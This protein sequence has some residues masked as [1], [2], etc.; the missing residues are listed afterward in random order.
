MTIHYK[1]SIYRSLVFA[2]VCLGILVVTPK[3]VGQNSPTKDKLIVETLLRLKRY[4]VSANENWKSAIDRHLGTI[5]GT[6]RYLELVE[7]FGIRDSIPDLLELVIASPADTIGVNAAILLLQFE[8]S[9]LLRKVIH[10]K[11]NIQAFAVAQALSLGQHPA[12]YG[13]L[14]P[15]IID[16]QV[17]RQIRNVAIKGVGTT[18]QG[19]QYLIALLMSG[20][21]PEELMF[22]TGTAL[23][24][25]SNPDIVKS[26][27]QLVSLPKTAGAA[28]LPPVNELLGLQGDPVAGKLVFGKNGT[29]IKCHKIREVGKEIGPSLTEIGSKL[30]KEA[31]F[32]SI[33][34]PS[35][36]VS[37]NYETYAI[38]LNSGNVLSGIV[39]SRSDEEVVVRNAEGIDRVIAVSNIDEII[40]TGISLMPADLQKVMTVQELVDVVAYL[41]QLK[42]S[43][44]GNP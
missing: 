23:F 31:L 14:K 20:R 33:L 6:P 9:V 1:T 41:T 42:K 2:T 39:V 37:H 7:V 43:T 24:S 8:Q 44:K 38:A 40:K 15:L 3:V 26:A 36:G 35:A 17:S 25:S 13:V 5:K 10:G 34:D 11:D 27:R 12:R 29:C 30:S 16:T 18:K 19:Q 32:V 4:D 22:V 28:P 21:I